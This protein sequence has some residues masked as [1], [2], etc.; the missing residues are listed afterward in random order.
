MYEVGKEDQGWSWKEFENN[1]GRP[2]YEKDGLKLLA[3]FIQHSD[4]KAPQQRLACQDVKVDVTSNPFRTT[5]T[6]PQML[7]QDVGA[8]FGGGGLFTNNSTAKM[9]LG[10]WSGKKVWNKA[11]TVVNQLAPVAEKLFD[12][13]D[14]E[15][16]KGKPAK[17]PPAKQP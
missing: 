11:K 3:A 4:N 12:K 13:L 2:S 8:T 5:C 1:N 6:Q 16:Q 17:A 9:N 15:A 14:Q 10:E 7:I